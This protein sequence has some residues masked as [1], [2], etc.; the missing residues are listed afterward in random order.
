LVVCRTAYKNNSSRYTINDKTSSF[1]EVTTLLKARGIDLEHKR[2]LIL[3]GEVESIAQMK[4]KAQTEHDEG[5]L[6]YL[7]DIIGT[8]GYKEPI[9]AAFADLEKLG[10]ERSEKLNRLRIVEREK[11]ALEERKKEA[12]NYLKDQNEYA[13]ALSRRF[14]WVIWDSGNKLEKANET[15]VSRHSKGDYRDLI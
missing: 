11:Q 5:L 10:E 1:T 6:E 15:I 9:E 4:P 8:S 13:R 14:Q 3:Q 12:D 7:E 2:F